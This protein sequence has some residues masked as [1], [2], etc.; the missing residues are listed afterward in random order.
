M[1][2]QNFVLLVVEKGEDMTFFT[3]SLF[4]HREMND[5][6]R[7]E[8][9][10]L[11]IIKE[12]IQTKSYVS[13]LVGRN[14]EFDEYVASL[15]KRAQKAVGNEN[16]DITL[17]LPYKVANLEYYEKYYDGVVIP[18]SVYGAHP[19]AAIALKNRWMVEQSDLV[20]VHVERDKGGAYTAMKYAEKLDKEVINLYLIEETDF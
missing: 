3:V 4:G 18:E 14:G 7:L 10:L 19:K 20:I 11:P 6:R 8:N 2:Q 15:I 5:L 13:F 17:A 16:S 9:Q 12:L 1:K